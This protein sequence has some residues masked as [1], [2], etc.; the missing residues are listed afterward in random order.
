MRGDSEYILPGKI[1]CLN[2]SD[3]RFF[4]FPR[5]IAGSACK[6]NSLRQDLFS[7]HK[8][9]FDD[10]CDRIFIGEIAV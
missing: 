9:L 6:R 1:V 2:I 5:D 8:W 3:K 10:G 7:I 4:T